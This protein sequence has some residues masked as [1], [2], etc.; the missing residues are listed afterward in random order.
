MA[1]R[2]TVR[3]GPGSNANYLKYVQTLI[4]A[5]K[6]SGHRRTN[7]QRVFGNLAGAFVSNTY[8]ENWADI[9]KGRPIRV[10][11]SGGRIRTE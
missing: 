8:Y 11:E 4:E 2:Y 5:G 10:L 1:E 7:G 9:E 3:V 6:K